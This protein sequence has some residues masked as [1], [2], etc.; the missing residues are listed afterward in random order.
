MIKARFQINGFELLAFQVLP[1]SYQT[2]NYLLCRN[3]QAAL[4]DAG[5]AMPVLKL[6]DEENLQL[7]NILITHTHGDHTG[8]CRALQDRL[9]IQSTSPG[10][11]A[12][13]FNVLGAVCRSISTPGHLAVCKS[14]YFPEPGI[15]FTGDTI[16]NGGC[17]RMMG[18]SGE[19]YF[20]SLQKLKALPET[21][22]IF[23][24]HDYLPENMRFAQSAEPNNP[25]IQNRITLYRTDPAAALFMTLADE[26][27]TNPF[28]RVE[29]AE[30]FIRLRRE[31]DVF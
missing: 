17:G 3:G 25:D 7:V 19:A 11:A 13:E 5:E 4:I 16:I 6:L 30:A 20:N 9:G 24:G 8:G 1:H 23:G 22:R 27:K 10:V 29:S 12:G 18:G 28:L 14:Y 21:T 31:K 15:V 2:F 26:M